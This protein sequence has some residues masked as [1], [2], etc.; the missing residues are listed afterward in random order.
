MMRFISNR[1]RHFSDSEEGS[2]V[3]PFAL[4]IPLFIGIIVSGIELGSVTIRNT[5]MERAL[6]QTVRD[7]RLGTGT[8]FTHDSIKQEICDGAAV[9]P[10]CMSLLK[11]EMVR[12][13]IR[14]WSDPERGADCVDTSLPVNPLREFENGGG[15]ELMLLRACYKYKP[16]SPATGLGSALAKDA[17][18]YSAIISTAAFVQEPL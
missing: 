7:V 1:L 13:D 5:A 8:V 11:L 10:N 14:D 18:G 6:D 17:Q 2:M 9:L 3:V 15:N 16:I 4:W 12:L